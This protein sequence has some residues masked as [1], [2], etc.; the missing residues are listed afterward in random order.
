M[1][2]Y[3]YYASLRNEYGQAEGRYHGTIESIVPL[4]S[5]EIYQEAVEMLEMELR[6]KKPDKNLW[7]SLHS[8]NRLN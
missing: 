8:L 2:I 3:H 7:F 5:K 4:D 1:T 6:K